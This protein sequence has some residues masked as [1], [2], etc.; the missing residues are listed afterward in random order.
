MKTVL[1]IDDDKT[2][3]ASL[4]EG[5]EDQS[6]LILEAVNGQRMMD[7]VT[8]HN[9]DIILLDLHLKDEKSVDLITPLREKTDAPIIIISGDKTPEHKI[10]MLDSG[11]DD[12]I[13]KPC[14]LNELKAR[15][16]ANLRRYNPN[17]QSPGR[18]KPP[19]DIYEFNGMSLD[20]QKHQLFDKNGVSCDLT[21]REFQLL[22]Y[23]TEHKHK[24][25]SREDLCNAIRQDR[26]LPSPRSIDIK[27]TRLRKKISDDAANPK[28]LKT[29]RGIGYMFHPEE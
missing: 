7:I 19:T 1:I 20:R 16:R 29:V 26:Y 18:H 10:T 4:R 28:I 3:R 6:F 23:L 24:A 25:V 11:A 2:V 8:T 9:I 14:N 13:N 21:I 22:N 17:H 27:I 5:L 12:F 15:I